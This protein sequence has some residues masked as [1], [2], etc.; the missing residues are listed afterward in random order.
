MT[1]GGDA[2]YS[3]GQ[4]AAEAEMEANLFPLEYEKDDEDHGLFKDHDH[5]VKGTLPYPGPT[6]QRV[7]CRDRKALSHTHQ[8]WSRTP[9]TPTPSQLIMSLHAPSWIP[10]PWL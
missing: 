10:E 9:P 8:D 6:L 3:T 1:G 5:D 7:S 2:V 4:R